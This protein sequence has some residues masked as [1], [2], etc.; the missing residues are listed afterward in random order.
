MIKRQ[1]KRGFVMTGGGAKGL[2]E[3]GVIHAFHLCALPFDIITGSSI[4]AMNALFYA[5]Y[6]LHRQQLPTEVRK[7]PLQAIEAL[8]PLVKAFQHAWWDLPRAGFIDDSEE[9][10]LGQLKDDILEWEISIPVLVRLAWWHSTPGHWPVFP[11]QVWPHLVTLA[12]EGLERLQPGSRFVEYWRQKQYPPLEAALRAYLARFN[13]ERSLV[14]AESTKVHEFFVTPVTP[15]QPEHLEGK[16]PTQEGELQVIIQPERTMLDYVREGIDL[17]LTRANYR[18]GRLELSAYTSIPDFI[19][20]LDSR[21][22]SSDVI[23]GSSRLQIPGN[24]R[25]IDAAIASGRFPGVFAPYPIEALYN[26]GDEEGAPENA[27]LYRLLEEGLDDDWVRRILHDTYRELNPDVEPVALEYL[28]DHIYG[29]WASLPFPRRGDCYVDGGAI[30]NTPTNSAV[31]AIREAI[32]RARLDERRGA[33]SRQQARGDITPSRRDTVLDLYVVYLHSEPD[34]GASGEHDDPALYQVVSRTLKIKGAASLTSDAAMVKTINKFGQTGE[35]LGEGVRL[36][37][38]GIQEMDEELDETLS[39]SLDEEQRAEVAA[40]IRVRFHQILQQQAAA[41]GVG[42]IG[43]ESLPELLAAMRDWS[44]RLIEQ[45]LPLHVNP[46]EIYPDQMEMDTLQFTERLGFRRKRAIQA[47]TMGCY[48]TFWQ[49]RGYLESKEGMPEFDA[50]DRQTL[51]LARRWMGF[52][53]WPD[54][55][56]QTEVQKSW[57]CQRQQCAF[58]PRHCRHGARIA[59]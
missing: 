52:A 1:T 10:P 32:D 46:V 30:D 2:Y 27:F 28:W 25:A 53:E 42:Q 9:G 45:R 6:L 43:T 8:D 13:I 21:N 37:L 51:A 16:K 26:E 48:N 54:P 34:P 18:T 3:A 20:Y 11:A 56:L 31:D 57:Q 47:M 59:A 12:R 35:A 4:G 22:A 49:L 33:R 36:F 14:P 58:H 29:Y 39:G 55:A 41:A 38:A 24:P 17:R 23:I 15:L 44:D 7:D 50:V 19:D 5:E 40:A